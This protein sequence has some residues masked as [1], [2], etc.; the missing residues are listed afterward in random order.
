MLKPE[1]IDIT[2]LT[3][4]YHSRLMDNVTNHVAGTTTK[5]LAKAAAFMEADDMFIAVVREMLNEATAKITGKGVMPGCI[6]ALN[7]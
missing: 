3:T 2:E 4:R 6:G 7:S 5:D 1:I